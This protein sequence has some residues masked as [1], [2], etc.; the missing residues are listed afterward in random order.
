MAKKRTIVG[1]GLAVLF[2][3]AGV[4][5]YFF[6]PC[7]ECASICR[8]CGKYRIQR[9]RLGVMWY[10]HERDNDLSQW[11][12]ET[13]MRPH[14]HQWTPLSAWIRHWG[15][16]GECLDWFG[17]EV[18]PLRLLRDATQ[19]VDQATGKDLVR[20]YEAMPQDSAKRRAF[21]ERCDKILGLEPPRPN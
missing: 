12:Q 14:G 19:H 21:F 16:G 1:I 7:S 5:L 11:Y 4:G 10:D 6:G 20:E 3:A 9:T 17:W 15:G 2:V 8:V 18:E 13:G